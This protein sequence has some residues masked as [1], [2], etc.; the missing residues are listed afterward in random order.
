MCGTQWRKLNAVLR[1]L[2]FRHWRECNSCTCERELIE[3][4]FFCFSSSIH[5]DRHLAVYDTYHPIIDYSNYLIL[6]ITAALAWEL[7]SKPVYLDEELR[8]SFQM[9]NLPL[10]KRKDQNV[11]PVNY[12]NTTKDPSQSPSLETNAN[13]YSNY[14][15][16]NLP[17]KQNPFNRYY[18][19]NPNHRFSYVPN[20]IN[21]DDAGQ[22]NKL[23][24][25]LSYADRLMKEF[26]QLTQNIPK[27]RPFGPASLKDLADTYVMLC[28]I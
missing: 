26:K 3:F 2:L 18:A 11:S 5:V 4:L 27:D 25:Y 28:H 13:A 6:G 15:Y 16:T 9:G 21:G 10:L 1:I 20:G 7:P 19:V 22:S 8:D 12:A 24:Y 14:Y 23:Q 17:N